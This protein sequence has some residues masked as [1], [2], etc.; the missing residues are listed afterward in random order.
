[1]SNSI[2]IVDSQIL[3][4]STWDI[5]SD[6][7]PKQ[8]SVKVTT[9]FKEDEML[10]DGEYKKDSWKSDSDGAL[11]N[12]FDK[13]YYS[14]DTHSLSSNFDEIFS[15]VI[16]IDSKVNNSKNPHINVAFEYLNKASQVSDRKNGNKNTRDSYN[17]DYE[18]VL[19]KDNT[20][21]VFGLTKSISLINTAV[22]NG[23]QVSQQLKIF[24][25]SYA[26]DFSEVTLQS[27]C[28][29]LD[30]S[31]LKVS[32]SCSSV[33]LDGSET[34]GS[35]NATITIKYGNASGL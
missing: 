28:E 32:L 5:R 27:T 25:I 6:I 35:F 22:L 26:G 14:D 12:D 31:I 16:R 29:S 23:K 13:D 15:L 21:A 2:R 9:L 4:S 30:E 19:E 8:N 1:M 7:N 20:Q 34:R 3:P 10:A 18:L 17:L 24:R 33:Y 11:N